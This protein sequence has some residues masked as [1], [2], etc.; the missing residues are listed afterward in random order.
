ME[1]NTRHGID[2]KT[3][4][5]AGLCDW[6]MV[7]YYPFFGLDCDMDLEWLTNMRMT[8]LGGSPKSRPKF[9]EVI[10]RINPWVRDGS[11]YSAVKRKRHS[12]NVRM[13]SF[14]RSTL[15]R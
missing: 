12:F 11:T 10:G 15:N 5:D 3:W 1:M 8:S 13:R 6:V 7:S 14:A 9:T 2:I 4:I